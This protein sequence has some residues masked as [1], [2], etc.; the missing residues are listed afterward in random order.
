MPVS[1]ME[2]ATEVRQLLAAPQSVTLV[3]TRALQATRST[4]E[5]TL[6]LVAIAGGVGRSLVAEY[7]EL[8]DSIKA[9]IAK[10]NAS[11]RQLDAQIQALQEQA[12]KLEALQKKMEQPLAAI[13]EA[14]AVNAG[15]RAGRNIV[16]ERSARV[17]RVQEAATAAL[18][19]DQS[20][21]HVRARALLDK[22]RLL[23]AQMPVLFDVPGL[24]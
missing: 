3:R 13:E 16:S 21:F 17:R 9:D 15:C 6:R 23:V 4:D 19:S 7:Q 22:T 18:G 12:R 10:L 11:I 24:R 14:L 8:I 5:T 2:V 20:Q 1:A